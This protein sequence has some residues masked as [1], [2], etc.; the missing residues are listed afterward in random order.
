M[1]K[2]LENQKVID[3]RGYGSHLRVIHA[4]NRPVFI[5]HFC[6]TRFKRKPGLRDFLSVTEESLKSGFDCI[7]L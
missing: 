5:K 3:I 6:K 2:I 4:L 7:T 1:V